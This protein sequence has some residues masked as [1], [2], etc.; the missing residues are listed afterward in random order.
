[1]KLNNK[2][3]ASRFIMLCIMVIAIFGAWLYVR[4]L[5]S[6]GKIDPEIAKVIEDPVGTAREYVDAFNNNTQQRMDNLKNYD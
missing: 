3:K 4:H 2:G 6:T 1:M 5:A